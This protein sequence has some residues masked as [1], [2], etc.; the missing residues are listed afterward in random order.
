MARKGK[1]G[2]KA[3]A[4]EG[5]KQNVAKDKGGHGNLAKKEAGQGDNKRAGQVVANLGGFIF[6]CNSTTKT[7]CF[8]Y[9]V[10]GLNEGKKNLV[11][12]VRKGMRLF[13]FD[14]DLRL[15]YGI[16][17]A[18]SPGS[19]KLEPSA[20]GGA[21]PWQVRFH[22]QKDC[23]P[24]SED[25]FR[26]AIK[27]NYM[28]H[29]KFKVELTTEH[30]HRL[31]KLFRPLPGGPGRSPPRPRISAPDYFDAPIARPPRYPEVDIYGQDRQLS[32]RPLGPKYESNYNYGSTDRLIAEKPSPY[33]QQQLTKYAHYYP[34]DDRQAIEG[35]PQG[36][37]SRANREAIYGADDSYLGRES[38]LQQGLTRN[39]QIG[40]GGLLLGPSLAPTSLSSYSVDPLHS[41]SDLRQPRAR[42]DIYSLLGGDVDPLHRS[43]PLIP[44]ARGEVLDK[45]VSALD[46]LAG[47]VSALDPLAGRLSALD[48]LAE[49]LPY[50]GGLS[51]EMLR[52]R[53]PLNDT[54]ASGFGGLLPRYESSAGLLSG[55]AGASGPPYRSDILLQSRYYGA[56]GG[57]L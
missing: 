3:N 19:F 38:K 27:D 47:R 34:S 1:F 11:E 8:K 45:R 46:S 39:N 9:R 54:Y 52:G 42:D 48:P 13:L 26:A 43:R 40:V 7:D 24:L 18:A 37:A 30:V 49:S 29:R 36:I 32:G 5:P 55:T 35:H 6:M 51:S 15:L 41:L 22:I 28:D 50:T 2:N 53:P 17:V 4:K 57:V 20:F 44:D 16:Y 31:V 21:F 12:Q 14:I 10:F 25:L 56:G 23:L 33:A